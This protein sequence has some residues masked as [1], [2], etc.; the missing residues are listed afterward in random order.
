M[1]C[2]RKYVSFL[3]FFFFFGFLISICI[4]EASN[5]GG[6]AVSGLEMAQNSQRLAWTSKEVDGKLKNIM[7]ECYGVCAFS[8]L[9]LFPVVHHTLLSFSLIDLFECGN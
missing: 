3:F 6:V 2:P 8:H 4:Q 5:C 7:A 9:P 1:V